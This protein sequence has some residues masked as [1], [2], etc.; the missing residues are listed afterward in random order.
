MPRSLV[1]DS[2]PSI[3]MRTLDKP[4]FSKSPPLGLTM[5]QPILGQRP[6]ISQY[7]KVG[8]Q[9][10]Q[11]QELLD[12]PED[13]PQTLVQGSDQL[14]KNSQPHPTVMDAQIKIEAENY[15]SEP[16]LTQDDDYAIPDPP[17]SSLTAKNEADSSTIIALSQTI[18][19]KVYRK[20]PA[21]KVTKKKKPAKSSSHFRI[22]NKNN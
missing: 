18:P 4:L 3:Q 12:M 15:V 17:P 5:G 13:A 9:S 7:I 16:K 8:K 10:K 21:K 19:R 2:Y 22:V 6:R 14:L 11:I 1:I 20:K